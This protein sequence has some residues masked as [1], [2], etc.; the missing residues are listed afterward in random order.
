MHIIC[1]MGIEAIGAETVNKTPGTTPPY[2]MR[3]ALLREAIQSQIDPLGVRDFYTNFLPVYRQARHIIQ[4]DEQ[5]QEAAWADISCALAISP[6]DSAKKDL[7]L[8]ALPPQVSELYDKTLADLQPMVLNHR[9]K[10]LAEK[11]KN[12]AS[13]ISAQ[14]K[15]TRFRIGLMILGV[16]PNPARKS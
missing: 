1:S 4:T 15:R 8:S 9:Q 11:I 14:V 7:W 6:I 13:L 12:S 16:S 10:T 3:H 2:I 5:V